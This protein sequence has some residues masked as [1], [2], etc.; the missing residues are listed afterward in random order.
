MFSYEF[1][2]VDE[3]FV[4]VDPKASLMMARYETDPKTG[5]KLAGIATVGT[6]PQ[7]AEVIETNPLFAGVSDD[8]FCAAF[9]KLYAD[10]R[11]ETEEAA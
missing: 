1:L 8:E 2:R 9:D 3:T 7:L 11:R 5:E 10:A 6:R 4:G